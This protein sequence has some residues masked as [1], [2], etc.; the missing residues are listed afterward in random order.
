ML[1]W[2]VH[3]PVRSDSGRLEMRVDVEQDGEGEQGGERDDPGE[4]HDGRGRVQ[5]RQR[6]QGN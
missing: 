6:R 2:I 1:V 5:R 3:G 4:Q